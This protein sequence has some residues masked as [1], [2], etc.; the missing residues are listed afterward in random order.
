MPFNSGVYNRRKESRVKAILPVRV[1]RNH[2]SSVEQLLIAHTFDIS[3]EGARLGGTLEKLEV[4]ELVTLR[5]QGRRA[6]FKICRIGTN[7]I[8]LSCLE[9][10]K[11]LWD[12]TNEQEE[13]KTQFEFSRKSP[14]Q[15]HG[16]LT[17]AQ[18]LE[19]VI[20][21]AIGSGRRKRKLPA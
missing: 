12:L 2:G 13:S 11:D 6:Q 17:I 21:S 16:F 1:L 7:D 20:S 19:L 15:L 9:P 5:R 14:N 18:K 3:P 4:G 10:E 8:G